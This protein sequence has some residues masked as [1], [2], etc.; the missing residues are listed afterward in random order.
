L[1]FDLERSDGGRQ[2]QVKP[3]N[4][5]GLIY[6]IAGTSAESFITEGQRKRLWA[7]AKSELKLSDEQ[8]KGA[9]RHFGFEKAESITRDQYEPLIEY[10]KQSVKVPTPDLYPAHNEIV[11]RVRALTKHQPHWILAQC[12]HYGY[13]RPGMM[14]PPFGKSK[15]KSQKSK[16]SIF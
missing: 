10:L 9:L 8:I 13:D 12:K 1:T 5:T 16:L 3:K 11:K 7:I 4:E 15:V 2:P 14:P 6:A